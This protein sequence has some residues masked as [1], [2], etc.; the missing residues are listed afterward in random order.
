M[1]FLKIKILNTAVNCVTLQIDLAR[2]LGARIYRA[3]RAGGP[4][5]EVGLAQKK[6]FVDTAALTPGKT[7]YYLAMPWS[8]AWM[9]YEPNDLKGHNPIAVKVPRAPKEKHVAITRKRSSFSINLG[10]YLDESNTVTEQPPTYCGTGYHNPPHDKVFEP[11]MYVA[12]EN[13]GK[14]DVINPWLVANGQRDWWSV[15]T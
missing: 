1:N 12:I 11:N 9:L 8:S 3:Q 2:Q 10:G 7:Y 13:S 6:I 15:E 4:Y 14:K 5:E